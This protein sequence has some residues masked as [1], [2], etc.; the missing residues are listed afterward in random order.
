MSSRVEQL[1][2]ENRPKQRP[3]S[4]TLSVRWLA[5]DYAVVELP[6]DILEEFNLRSCLSMR[7]YPLN[8][9]VFAVRMIDIWMSIASDEEKK[10]EGRKRRFQSWLSKWSLA[11]EFLYDEKI[12]SLYQSSASTSDDVDFSLRSRNRSSTV[13]PKLARPS[14]EEISRWKAASSGDLT[15]HHPY[16][17]LPSLY[18]ILMNETG[19]GLCLAKD[20]KASPT[21]KAWQKYIFSQAFFFFALQHNLLTSPDAPPIIPISSNHM[22]DDVNANIIDVSYPSAESEFS[23]SNTDTASMTKDDDKGLAASGELPIIL[24]DTMEEF[25]NPSEDSVEEDQQLSPKVTS[26]GPQREITGL[27]NGEVIA[28]KVVA[29]LI[30]TGEPIEEPGV[31]YLTNYRLIFINAQI[32]ASNELPI[33]VSQC[34]ISLPMCSC[35]KVEKTPYR[36]RYSLE[37]SFLLTLSCKDFRIVRIAVLA[38]NHHLYEWLIRFAFPHYVFAFQHY[39]GPLD[40]EELDGWS[41][42]D[43]QREFLRMGVGRADISEPDAWRL[44]RAN[45]AYTLCDSYPRVVCVPSCITDQVLS[46]AACFRMRKRFPALCWR[47]SLKPGAYIIRCAQPMPGLLRSRN[48]DDEA[49]VDSIRMCS[50]DPTVSLTIMDARPRSNAMA[51][52]AKGAGYEDTD[53]YGSCDLQFM[54]IANIHQMRQSIIALREL[55]HEIVYD[56]KWKSNI[57]GTR[58]LDHLSTVLAAANRMVEILWGNQD[59]TDIQGRPVL[60][61]CS[62][63]WD[64]TSQIVTLAQ[65][66]LDPYYRTIRGFQVLVEK[67]WC[68]FGH[69]FDSR[70]GHADSNI[71]D[72]NRSPI[73]LQFLD[74]VY[75]LVKEH[76]TAFEFNESLL[77]LI[78]DELYS[79]R[80]GTFLYNSEMERKRAS[81]TRKCVS[82]WTQ[83]NTHTYEY[84]NHAYERPPSLDVDG[85][86][87]EVDEPLYIS[88]NPRKLRFWTRCY[89]KWNERGSLIQECREYN[90]IHQGYAQRLVRAMGVSIARQKWI[91]L[92]SRQLSVYPNRIISLKDPPEFVLDLERARVY[93]TSQRTALSFAIQCGEETFE[94]SLDDSQDHLRWLSVLQRWQVCFSTEQDTQLGESFTASI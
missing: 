16:V 17:T 69:M 76:P 67:D 87:K 83:V 9:K 78:A 72:V 52:Y 80:F 42:Y 21:L 6:D 1:L 75:Q 89:L 65:I 46:N 57:E 35:E 49:L 39:F 84:R 25:S 30:S 66:M 18:Y 14:F 41:V 62:D 31:V 68:S 77:L 85:S 48:I 32:M 56:S 53:N 12:T 43:P 5:F 58:W 34:A 11:I 8:G 38:A 4:Q 20:P 45:C 44:S 90:I 94:F 91:V 86:I 73:F 19:S 81:V 3:L 50:G 93:D 82:L 63:G 7:F 40:D 60:I 2:E 51:N 24:E 13:D 10:I 79:C 64:R 15:E 26:Q 92:E 59:G 23:C 28:L 47:S 37:D 36:A 22:T 74:C 29:Y 71:A 33:S 70:V 55:C 61:H 54:G 27:L 88:P